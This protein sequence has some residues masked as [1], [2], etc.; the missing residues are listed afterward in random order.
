M[1]DAFCVPCNKNVSGK[2][3]EMK[4]LESGK[5]LY[6]GECPNCAYQIKRI[7]IA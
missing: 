2:L 7:V 3:T 1:L 4:V 5:W 6:I